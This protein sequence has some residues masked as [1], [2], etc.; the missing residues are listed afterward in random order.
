MIRQLTDNYGTLYDYTE[1]P[2][3]FDD[4][5]DL[6]SRLFAMKMIERTK[7]GIVTMTHKKEEGGPDVLY[8][9]RHGWHA[10]EVKTRHRNKVEALW[11][12]DSFRYGESYTTTATTPPDFE[13]ME[14]YMLK[15][16]GGK[17]KWSTMTECEE[18]LM[19]IC[20]DGYWLLNNDD[21]VDA[22]K[23]YGW[24]S[25]KATNSTNV[26]WDESVDGEIPTKWYRMAL[27]D[28]PEKC[29]HDYQVPVAIFN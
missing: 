8:R 6:Y 21:L 29:W 10:V 22:I 14:F 17:S 7:P 11:D 13:G 15:D 12:A 5:K 20:F 18:D 19:V 16:G 27:L 25:E 9:Y 28:L 23:G 2:G 1:H 24:Y 4:S 26:T 3:E